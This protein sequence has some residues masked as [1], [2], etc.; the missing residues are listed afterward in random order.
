MSSWQYSLVVK[1]CSLVTRQIRQGKSQVLLRFFQIHAKK[2]TLVWQK[3][4]TMSPPN[5]S[6]CKP[7]TV[8]LSLVLLNN[9]LAKGKWLLPMAWCSSCRIFHSSTLLFPHQIQTG[10]VN[11]WSL[12]QEGWINNTEEI[13]RKCIYFCKDPHMPLLSFS[14][15]WALWHTKICCTVV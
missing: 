4:P 14:G 7:P 2:V 5:Y 15:F 12:H 11:L 3:G 13:L 9:S 1:Y 6:N 10:A 8:D